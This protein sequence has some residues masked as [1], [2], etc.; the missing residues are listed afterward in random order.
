M[1]YQFVAPVEEAAESDARRGPASAKAAA[2]VALAAALGA[3]V[4]TQGRFIED[5]AKEYKAVPI[6]QDP[7][8]TADPAVSDDEKWLAYTSD[9]DGGGDLDIWV[10]PFPMRKGD[11]P[12]Q[13]TDHPGHEIRPDLAPDGSAVVYTQAGGSTSEVKLLFL[14]E[15]VE[16]R[17]GFGDHARFSPDGRF[18]S[19]VESGVGKLN[20]HSL[21]DGTTTRIRP[22]F[23]M[24]RYHDWLPD[25]RRI[26]FVGREKATE[27]PTFWFLSLD[28]GE[29]VKGGFDE[30][31]TLSTSAYGLRWVPKTNEVL[32]G[33]SPTEDLRRVGFTPNSLRF[34]GVYERIRAPGPMMA[35]YPFLTAAGLIFGARTMTEDVRSIEVERRVG[36]HGMRVT[37]DPARIRL[38]GVSRDGRRLLYRTYDETGALR[39]WVRDLSTGIDTLVCRG[40][41]SG[42]GPKISP[43]GLKV[44]CP[45]IESAGGPTAEARPLWVQ[46]LEDSSAKLLCQECGDPAAWT[47]DGQA[48]LTVLVDRDKPLYRVSHVSAETGEESILLEHEPLRFAG[49]FLSPDS[50]WIY[51]L[52]WE[53]ERE[54]GTRV[55]RVLYAAPM[56]LESRI[57]REEWTKIVDLPVE[58]PVI[59]DDGRTI[60]FLSRR[61]GNLCVWAQHVIPAAAEPDGEPFAVYHS[62][63]FRASITLGRYFDVQMAFANGRLYFPWGI[64]SGNV[65]MYEGFE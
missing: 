34:N 24:I 18:V 64:S 50:R 16:R 23:E 3:V 33:Y 30:D 39:P 44:A 1:G 58:A 11:A 42:R 31:K 2:A 5:S 29:V 15:G 41:E 19:F 61:D 57:A 26:L 65:W 62:H 20:V 59:S 53:A 36:D 60:Y 35:Q 10:Q 21:E 55:N 37:D 9:R 32:F 52:A 38:G 63:N 12:R 43:D 51:F 22:D 40:V 6:T 45:G 8:L 14:A 54:P 4:V 17:L 48:I 28:S 49:S 56:R 13:I 7:G 25:S 46:S 47:P 27:T